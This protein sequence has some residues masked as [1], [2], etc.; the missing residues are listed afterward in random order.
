MTTY[1]K[2][3]R[4]NSDSLLAQGKVLCRKAFPDIETHKE[5][6]YNSF[7]HVFRPQKEV[8]DYPSIREMI[9]SRWFFDV[10]GFLVSKD[11]LEKFDITSLWREY[12][13]THSFCASIDYAC[14]HCRRKHKI[15]TSQKE[16]FRYCEFC[17]LSLFPSLVIRACKKGEKAM[18]ITYSLCF[19]APQQNLVAEK[20]D[21]RRN[22]LLSARAFGGNL[23]TSPDSKIV[24]GIT[25][26][27]VQRDMATERLARAVQELFLEAGIPVAASPLHGR[28]EKIDKLDCLD[29]IKRDLDDGSPLLAR[30]LKESTTK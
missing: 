3:K 4:R 5:F 10:D 21:L 30:I 24:T 20:T 28:F 25:I 15:S 14:Q 26:P 7:G 2:E 29:E 1:R 9:R 16:N 17:S 22:L 6:H 19:S 18:R 12:A 8:T 13:H 27:D 23:D 11:G